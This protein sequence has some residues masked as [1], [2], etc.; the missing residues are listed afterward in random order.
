MSQDEATRLLLLLL[1]LQK[2]LA[3]GQSNPALYNDNQ[4]PALSIALMEPCVNLLGDGAWDLIDILV[5]ARWNLQMKICRAG[6]RGPKMQDLVASHLHH[7][8]AHLLDPLL[9]S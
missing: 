4:R 1:V 7:G 8:L 9:G 5:S 3:W 2:L 6:L